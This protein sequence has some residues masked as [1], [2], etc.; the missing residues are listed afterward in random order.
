MPDTLANAAV[1]AVDPSAAPGQP[2]APPAPTP[3]ARLPSP[4]S[5]VQSGSVPAISLAPIQGKK[6]DPLQEFVVQNLDEISA[7]GVDYHELPDHHS[8]LFNP[9]KITPAQI[10]AADKAGKLFEVA[11]LARALG[12]LNVATETGSQ[13][14]QMPPPG[15]PALSMSAAAPTGTVHSGGGK[16]LQTARLKTAAASVVGSSDPLGSLSQRAV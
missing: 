14:A 1:L 2:L 7:A 15:Q 9:A 12:P 13:A 16:K 8:V 6:T 5:D 4:I 11:P 3:V 10:D